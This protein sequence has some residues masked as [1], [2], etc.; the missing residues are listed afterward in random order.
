MGHHNNGNFETFAAVNFSQILL[1]NNQ[2]ILNNDNNFFL[3]DLK[4]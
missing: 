3:S 1:C 4:R 2:Y